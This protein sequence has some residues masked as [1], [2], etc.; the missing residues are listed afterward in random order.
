MKIGLKVT[1]KN[2][3]LSDWQKSTFRELLLH[4][5]KIKGT[6]TTRILKRKRKYDILLVIGIK[7][8]ENRQIGLK[9]TV[10]KSDVN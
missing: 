2:Q 9:V 10:K 8:K 7:I 6:F 3:T 1:G 5:L 4:K